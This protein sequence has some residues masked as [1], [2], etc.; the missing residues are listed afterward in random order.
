MCPAFIHDLGAGSMS[1]IAI[2]LLRQNK[3]VQMR[4]L[5]AHNSLQRAVEVLEGHISINQN[6]PPDRRAGS[7]QRYFDRIHFH[8]TGQSEPNPF[9]SSTLTLA[10]KSA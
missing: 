6:A 3:L 4:I 7:Q 5:P 10:R 2:P 1:G 8:W 9:P